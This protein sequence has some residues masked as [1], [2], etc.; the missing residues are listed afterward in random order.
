MRRVG[1]SV[2]RGWYRGSKFPSRSFRGGFVVVRSRERRVQAGIEQAGGPRA[3][4]RGDRALARARHDGA[5]PR[6]QRATRSGASA[7]STGR[8]PPTTRWAC[9]TPGAA[10]TRTSSS[11]TTPC[12]ASGS[13]TRTG[14]TARGCGSRSRSRSELGFNDKRADRGVRDRPVRRAV[15]GA[16]RHLRRHPDR[17]EQAPRLSGWTGTTATTR[18]RDENNYTIWAFLAECHAAA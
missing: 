5:L 2:K 4:A 17:A 18:T 11:A 1:A 12:S 6:A 14:S 10:P 15:Q 9:I 16:G 7:S 8:S 13:A 3:R